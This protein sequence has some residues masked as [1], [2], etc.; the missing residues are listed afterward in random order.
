MYIKKI[1]LENVGP[2]SNLEIELPFHENDKPK[3]IVLVGEN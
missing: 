3:P 2:I 1:T